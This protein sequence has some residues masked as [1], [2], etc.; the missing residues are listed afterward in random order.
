MK[1]E[2]KPSKIRKIGIRIAGKTRYIDHF[3]VD[4]LALT[5]FGELYKSKAVKEEVR[6]LIRDLMKDEPDL[7]PQ[8]FYRKI[9]STFLSPSA[10]KQIDNQKEEHE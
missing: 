9:L 7:H 10:R 5:N 4:A 1:K 3:F 6:K 2:I 8:M